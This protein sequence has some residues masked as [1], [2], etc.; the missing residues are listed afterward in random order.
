MI[1]AKIIL[2]AIFTF[3]FITIVPFCMGLGLSGDASDDLTMLYAWLVCM[4]MFVVV[5]I[6]WAT[7]PCPFAIK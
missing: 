1:V 4:V 3:I 2:L 5:V 7:V 6:L